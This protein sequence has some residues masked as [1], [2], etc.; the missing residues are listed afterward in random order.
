MLA[1]IKWSYH[2]LTDPQV[3]KMVELIIFKLTWQNISELVSPPNNL[4]HVEL[5]SDIGDGALT[6]I[7]FQCPSLVTLEL[8]LASPSYRITDLSLCHSMLLSLPSSLIDVV[9]PNSSGAMHAASTTDIAKSSWNY[10]LRT[11]LCC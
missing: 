2:S 9:L 5:C 10:R 7:A 1:H 8:T 6:S 3:S 4:T 11:I